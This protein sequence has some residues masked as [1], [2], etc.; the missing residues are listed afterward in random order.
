MAK[1]AVIVEQAADGGWGAYSDVCGSIIGG[2][3][4]SRELAIEDWKEAMGGW[5]EYRREKGEAVVIPDVELV[6]VEVAG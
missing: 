6:T 3:G 2:L 5:L 1:F 4:E